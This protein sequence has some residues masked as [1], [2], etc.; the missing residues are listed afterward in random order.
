MSHGTNR[1]SNPRAPGVLQR[2]ADSFYRH[3]QSVLAVWVLLL[4]ALVSISSAGELDNDFDLP[5]L[6]IAAGL[7]LVMTMVAAGA[8]RADRTEP[9]EARSDGRELHG[10]T[11]VT[12]RG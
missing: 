2:L 12:G 9:N 5:V 10:S 6:A 11:R 3:R 4:V 1:T 8:V 7:G